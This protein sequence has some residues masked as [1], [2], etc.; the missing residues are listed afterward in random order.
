MTIGILGGGLL[1]YLLALAGYPLGFR[2]RFLDPSPEAPVGRIAQRITANFDD[3][4]ALEKFAAGLE[5]VT[6]E[7]ENVPVETVNFLAKRV[8]VFPPPMALEQ[9]QDRVRE[10]H[11]FQKLG[12]STTEFLP[13][14]RSEDLD[15]AIETIGL[16]C[17]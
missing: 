1:G 14:A 10:K 16:P 7:F 17:V 12:I 2:F 5:A 3:C 6:Y 11:F 4:A 15:S 9:A 13:I 8:A